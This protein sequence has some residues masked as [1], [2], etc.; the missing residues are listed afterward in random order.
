MVGG[1]LVYQQSHNR[2]AAVQR[3]LE[4]MGRTAQAGSNALERPTP[5][6][7]HENE[8]PR[9]VKVGLYLDRVADLSIVASSW[10]A[11]FFV[12]FS[13]DGPGLNPGEDFDIVGGE[14]LSK[15]LT[16]KKDIGDHH[17]LQYRVIAQIT[18]V[19]E[20]SRFPRDEHVLSISIE[21]RVRQAH[22]LEYVPDDAAS[23]VS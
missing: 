14:V 23:E 9:K 15:T 16:E 12:W 11:D 20:L 1:S 5:P 4:R 7:G 10:K 3:H 18:K 6:A 21:D 19:F 22:Q 13:W 17:Y 2:E 8:V